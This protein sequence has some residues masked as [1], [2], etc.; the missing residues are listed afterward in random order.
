MSSVFLPSNGSMVLPP[1]NRSYGYPVQ[2]AAYPTAHTMMPGMMPGMAPMQAM[3]P[4]LIYWS[5]VHRHDANYAVPRR[6]A[7]AD[8]ACS[9]LH[10]RGIPL[11]W[12]A[13]APA[14]DNYHPKFVEEAQEIKFI[15][16]VSFAQPFKE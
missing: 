9:R 10:I 7:H 3:R 2:H 13:T 15:A 12:L 11:L 16:F 14:D 1:T 4:M 6:D 5:P 8:D